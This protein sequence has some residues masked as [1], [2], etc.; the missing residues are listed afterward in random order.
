MKL[1]LRITLIFLVSLTGTVS[2]QDIHFSQPEFSPMS[3]NPSLTG[4]EGPLRFSVNYRNQWPLV[5]ANFNTIEAGADIKFGDHDPLRPGYLSL[6]LLMYSDLAN[7]TGVMNNKANLNLSYQ[8]RIDDYNYFGTGLYFGFGQ[9]SLGDPDGKWESQYVNYAYDP[10]MASGETFNRQSFTYGDAGFGFNYQYDKGETSMN[11]N[12][13]RA[14]SAGF[15][16]YHLNR[17][18]FSFTD[19]NEEILPIRFSY[20]VSADIGI[21]NKRTSILPGL[22]INHQKGAYEILLGS[23]YRY[24]IMEGSKI[25][26]FKN[27]T[28]VSGGVFYRVNDALILKG[29]LEIKKFKVGLAYDVNVSGLSTQ[30]KTI[31]GFEFFLMYNTRYSKKYDGDGTL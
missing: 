27:A 14:L 24:L 10:A 12:N 26:G 1:A 19:V 4:L 25:T 23:Y 18:Q 22:Y 20:F 7:G 6:G 28:A 29:L 5:G 16:M 2:A 17:P 13:R 8:F 30:S 31:G 3:L 9:R 15:A 21:R 11:K